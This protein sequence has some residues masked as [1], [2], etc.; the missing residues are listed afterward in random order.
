MNCGVGRRCG[1]DPAWLWH[2]PAAVALI[3]PLTWETP[4]AT[5]TALKRQN[6]QT[7]KNKKQKT[8]TKVEKNKNHNDWGKGPITTG[9]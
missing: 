1:L 6:K 3:Q 2:R 7:N 4:Y 8:K 9:R 5:G